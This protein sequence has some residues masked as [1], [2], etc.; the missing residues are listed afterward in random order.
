MNRFQLP[1]VLI[2]LAL[3][4]AALLHGC[5]DTEP[6][7]PAATAVRTLTL[8]AYT[9]PR[10]A[11]G[12]A[13]VPAF[14]RYWRD[15]TGEDVRFEE[16]YLGS[17]AQ[18]R[19]IVGGFE[20]DVAALSLEADVETIV[21]AG[22][23]TRDWKA[24]P[25]QGMVTRSIVVIAVPAGNPKGI[26][27]WDD[28]RRPGLNV[29]T[30]NVRTSGGAMWN[31][32]AIYG[33]ALRG[34]TGA[35]KGDAAAAEALL[36]GVLHNVSIM[37]KGARESIVS[38]EKGL[39]DAAITYENEVLVGR[40]AGR[41]SDYVVPRATILIENPAAVVDIYADKHGNRDLAD[42]FVAFLTTPAAQRA[43]TDFGLRPV[44]AGVAAETKAQ[45][46]AVADLFTIRDLGGWPTVTQ[47]LFTPG[48]VYDRVMAAPKP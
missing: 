47:T 23:I 21:Q 25:H 43:F 39:G 14:Q 37:D 28:L 36:G 29:L 26:H 12:K 27:D 8:G 32:G 24:G 18:A 1:Q 31:V 6:G 38:F 33:A 3:M 13:I 11:Y 7:R 17:G 30:P 22:L 35:P 10:E 48:G 41:D 5:G 46:P 19:A 15:K 40:K 44:D 20:A 16:S 42:A 4:S 34:G 9:T 2:P 45:F